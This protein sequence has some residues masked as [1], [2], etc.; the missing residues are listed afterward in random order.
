MNIDE[1]Q[2]SPY[3]SDAILSEIFV[4]EGETVAWGD[5][6]ARLSTPAGLVPIFSTHA[7]R[8]SWMRRTGELVSPNSVLCRVTETDHA[9][10]RTESLKSLQ[11]IL[12]P[13]AVLIVVYFGSLPH[14]F[15]LFV[16]Q[17]ANNAW[18][19][20]KLVTDVREFPVP[21]PSNLQM[22]DSSLSHVAER[23]KALTGLRVALDRAYKLCDIRPLYAELFAELVEGFDWWGWGDLDVL[24]GDLSEALWPGLVGPYAMVMTQGSLCLNRN[25]PFLKQLYKTRL[26]GAPYF[27]DV[28]TDPIS[29]VFDETPGFKRFAAH[30]NLPVYRPPALA[31]IDAVKSRFTIGS[32]Y[33]REV[34]Y[35]A[36]WFVCRAG[37]I[38]REAWH[39]GQ[40]LRR[41]FGYIH[42]QKRKFAP[43]TAEVLNAPAFAIIPDRFVAIDDEIPSPEMMRRSNRHS[44]IS[45]IAYN[46][47]GPLRRVRRVLRESSLRLRHALLQPYKRTR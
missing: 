13:R 44:P 41:E 2:R 20:V 18:L 26:P 19:T 6:L 24:Y 3:R 37:R 1:Q 17:C 45:D 25:T 30:Y 4:R 8:V 43:L 33:S 10:A 14:W 32:K 34:D 12:S 11:P 23:L 31:D 21:C 35:D 22:V 47:G 15:P 7:G 36:Q 9:P 40:F 46:F 27:E 42:L 29:R 39:E 28:V 38:Y 5:G 16:R